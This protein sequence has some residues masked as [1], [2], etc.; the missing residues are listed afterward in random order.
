MSLTFF[1]VGPFQP[2]CA[3]QRLG[4]PVVPFLN[5]Q[6]LPVV[7]D[8]KEDQFLELLGADVANLGCRDT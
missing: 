6:R 8:V 1:P 3:E 2:L 4:Q 7:N 5:H